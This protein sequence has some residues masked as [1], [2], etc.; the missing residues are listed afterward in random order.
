MNLDKHNVADVFP[1]TALQQGMIYHALASDD[2]SMYLEQYGFSVHGELDIRRYRKAWQQTLDHQPMLRTTF[3]WEGLS[4]AYQVIHNHLVIRFEYA[5]LS[6][7]SE[8][9]QKEALD[10]L[11]QKRRTSGFNLK[12]GP[13]FTVSV[14]ALAKGYHKVWLTL[15]HLLVDGWS[16]TLLLS[17]VSKRYQC[18]TQ[19]IEPCVPFRLYCEWLEAQDLQLAQ[20][21][22]LNRFSNGNFV[23]TAPLVRH[24]RN[25]TSQTF[26]LVL[27]SEDSDRWRR[28]CSRQGLTESSVFCAAW[29]ILLSRY[30]YQDR[31]VFGYTVS[32]RP[33]D[34]SDIDR[35]LGLLLN[36]LPINVDLDWQ[37]SSADW[38]Q[39]FQRQLL[40]DRKFDY[41]P[42]GEI[43]RLA[44]IT[45]ERAMFESLLVWENQPGSTAG[46]A[47]TEGLQIVHDESYE[48][49]HYPLMLA[50]YPGSEVRL[51]LTCSTGSLSE[52]RAQSMLSEMSAAMLA[53]A[54][55]NS[56]ALRDL[57][58]NAAVVILPAAVS[59]ASASVGPTGIWERI[60]ELARQS[61]DALQLSEPH[62]G[63]SLSRMDLI[64]QSRQLACQLA[65]K[66]PMDRTK[67]IALL[68]WPGTTY[69][70][71]ILAALQLGRPW[72]ALDPRK[73]S[74]GLALQLKQ[75]QPAA[76]VTDHSLWPSTVLWNGFT[77]F[78]TSLSDAIPD[79]E[80]VPEVWA[81]DDDCV[82]MVLTSGSTGKP[83]CVRLPHSALRHRLEWMDSTYPAD[84]DDC[85]ILKTS[86]IFVDAVCEVFYFPAIPWLL[87]NQLKTWIWS[88]CTGCW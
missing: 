7:L 26:D 67:P 85:M 71:A 60:S 41:L 86:P 21:W 24:H 82:C 58:N 46:E 23:G 13:L 79:S 63:L 44:G 66:L 17:E 87:Q 8:T 16:L 70:S 9:H 74:E 19:V 56:R 77:L 6:S 14:V 48:R 12:H 76:L 55:E 49:N 28:G 22:W 5:D 20:Q 27:S 45:P 40:A 84:R 43:Q 68:L 47:H 29:A 2:D 38:L 39:E 88:S 11:R 15:H 78:G 53:L 83:K 51:R 72:L 4:K 52:K 50:G 73:P 34:I 59:I 10:E 80:S 25:G 31:V 33:A 69:V 1:A 32:T 62:T 65:D 57:P 18:P 35:M 42:L 61:P 75:V 64:R 81:R 37:Q 36:V 3:L 30:L 54:E